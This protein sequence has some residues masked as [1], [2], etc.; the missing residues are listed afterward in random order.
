[1]EPNIQFNLEK[2]VGDKAGDMCEPQHE[3]DHSVA[4]NAVLIHADSH[5]VAYVTDLDFM[6]RWEIWR[7]GEFAQEGCS[8]SEESSKE[9][10]S[11]VLSFFRRLDLAKEVPGDNS[12]KIQNLLRGV[13]ESNS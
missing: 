1:M 10:V 3:S 12:H 11:H 4:P 7:E 9:A 8:L 5:Y 2:Q 13:G 6:W